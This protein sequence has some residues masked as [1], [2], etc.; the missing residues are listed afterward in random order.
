[1]VN[2]W[3]KYK[4]ASKR[5]KQALHSLFVGL[6]FFG[7]LLFISS[8]FQITLCP[9]QRFFGIPCFGCGLTRGMIAILHFDFIGA[10]RY[11]VL[12][13]PIFIG[14][15]IYAVICITDILFNRNDLR[16]ISELGRRKY[17]FV[18]YLIFLVVSVFVNRAI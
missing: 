14:G 9:L 1:M 17:M 11:H 13:I 18:I 4:E 8:V 12:S 2:L 16:R 15:V 3:R 7:V 5:Q 6:A 10:I